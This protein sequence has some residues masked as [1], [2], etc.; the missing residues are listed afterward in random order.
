MRAQAGQILAELSKG[1]S[2]STVAR[3]FKMARDTVYAR[4]L[5][6][7]RHLPSLQSLRVIN[8]GRSE[9][10][11]E[12]LSKRLD[13]ETSTMDL[14][15]GT[16]ELRA[17]IGQQIDWSKADTPPTAD[18]DSGPRVD[19][20]VAEAASENETELQRVRARET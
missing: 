2:I 3:E 1:K 13:E 14:I 9:E 18:S 10:L 17:L 16:A 20:W 6:I 11:I 15:R 5:L 19:E 7:S 4:L 8:F 12:R